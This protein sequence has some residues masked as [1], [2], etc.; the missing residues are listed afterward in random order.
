MR[1]RSGARSM[2]VTVRDDLSTSVATSVYW[3]QLQ[4]SFFKAYHYQSCAMGDELS[5]VPLA[6]QRTA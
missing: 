5:A 1:L 2:L 3:P 6:G 4:R